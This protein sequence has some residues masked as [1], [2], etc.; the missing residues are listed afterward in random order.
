[1]QKLADA[2]PISPEL[3]AKLDADRAQAERSLRPGFTIKVHDAGHVQYVNH[4]GSD[5]DIVAAARVSYQGKGSKGPAA[6]RKLLRYLFKHRHTSPFEM[7]KVSLIIKLPI[8]VMRQYIRHRMQNVNEVSARYSELP[9]EFYVPAEWRVQDKKNK[10]GST[11]THQPLKLESTWTRTDVDGS[12]FQTDDPTLVL[13]EGYEQCYRMYQAFLK[14]GIAREQA[15]IILPVGIYTE[16]RVCWDMNNLLKFFTLRDDPHA[17]GEH[18]DY[19]QAVKQICRKLF[20]LTMEAYDTIKWVCI[21]GEAF[22]EKEQES[23]DELESAVEAIV[24]KTAWR[25]MTTAPKNSTEVEVRLKDGRVLVAHWAQDLSGEEQPP[26]SGW[27]VYNG[28]YCSG[29]D[30][31]VAWRPLRK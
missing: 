25:G 21:D 30:E 9:S 24:S 31:P 29:I 15:R 1:M 19:A 16:A 4:M 13:M 18:Q 7:V 17:Q 6:D 22:V 5:E 26:F 8:F 12:T 3:R 28:S 23:W 2:S 10:Q 27:F 11:S 14:A 20:P